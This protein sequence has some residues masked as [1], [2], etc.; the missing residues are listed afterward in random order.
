MGR[1][2]CL[3]S[4]G[5]CQVLS[6]HNDSIALTNNLRFNIILIVTVLHC[7]SSSEVRHQLMM[8][9]P[10]KHKLLLFG[11][12]RERTDYIALC[13]YRSWVSPSAP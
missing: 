7:S 9:L 1:I 3:T 4:F 11:I 10:S 12:S 5:V 6:T 8:K 2:E 13:A